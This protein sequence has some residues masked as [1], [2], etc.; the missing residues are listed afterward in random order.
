MIDNPAADL[1]ELE[2]GA[3]VP[4]SFVVSIADGVVTIDPPGGLFELDE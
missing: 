3:L 4:A 2:S 1:L